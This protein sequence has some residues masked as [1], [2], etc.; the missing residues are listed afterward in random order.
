MH[1]APVLLGTVTTDGRGA[2]STTVHIPADAAPGAH[3][4]I[5]EG[6]GVQASSPVQVA[7]A[8]SEPSELPRTGGVPFGLAG[9]LTLVTGA[10]LR[11]GRR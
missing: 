9:L 11:L 4:L 10:A 5:V 1:S 3:S 8:T 2:F 7:A 6:G